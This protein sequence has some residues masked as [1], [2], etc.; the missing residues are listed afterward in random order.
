MLWYLDEGPWAP[1]NS[2][3]HSV[4]HFIAMLA[5]HKRRSF[6]MRETGYPRPCD[7][8]AWVLM[9]VVCGIDDHKGTLAWP[10]RT[11]HM[12]GFISH[13]IKRS[14]K[15]NQAAG[16]SLNL[17]KINNDKPAAAGGG[18][19]V[20]HSSGR[21]ALN[22]AFRLAQKQG[23]YTA[24][25]NAI[26]SGDKTLLAQAQAKTKHISEISVEHHLWNDR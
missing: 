4:S 24:Y 14:Q 17:N 1:L 15:K 2:I 18:E 21:G 13:L 6:W 12:R 3:T 20:H 10:D 19:E 8:L 16:L 7:G 5:V 22:K 25:E 9:K 26:Q 11:D 23:L